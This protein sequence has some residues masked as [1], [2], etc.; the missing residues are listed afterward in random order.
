LIGVDDGGNSYFL[1]GY[2]AGKLYEPWTEADV[3]VYSPTG[4]KISEIPVNLDSFNKKTS[5]EQIKLDIHGNIFQLWSSED[6]IHI[7]KW[8]KN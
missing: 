3:M 5:F 1:C 2:L 8:S 6:G 4:Q 7:T